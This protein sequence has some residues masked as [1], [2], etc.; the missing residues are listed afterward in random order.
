MTNRYL[1]LKN[2]LYSFCGINRLIHSDKKKGIGMITGFIFIMTVF[3]LYE[4]MFYLSLAESEMAEC[5]PSL[6]VLISSLISLFLT[7]LKSQ[8]AFVGMKDY[9]MTMSLPVKEIDIIIS[10]FIF[11]YII[12]SAI[13]LAVG[14]PADVVYAVSSSA[15]TSSWIIFGI[16]LLFIPVIPMTVSLIAGI[17]I[18][19][20]SLRSKHRNAVSIILSF[21]AVI[22]IVLFSFRTQN[23]GL[24]RM[25]D[26][27]QNISAAAENLYLPAEML[28][29]AVSESSWLLLLLFSVFSVMPALIFIFILAKYYKRINTASLSHSL[30]YNM[31]Q[32]VIR[33]SVPFTALYRKELKMFFS[34]T[35]Y[36][37]NSSVGMV[38]MAVTSIFIIFIPIG[39]LGSLHQMIRQTVPLIGAVFV[40]ISSTTSSSLSLEGDK[41]WIMCSLPVASSEIVKSKIALNLTIIVPLL[42]ISSAAAG[43]GLKLDLFKIITTIAVAASY[44]LYIS[45]L[46]IYINVKF[47]KYDWKSEY[48]AVKGSVSVLLTA[49]IGIASSLI[50]LMMC[51]SFSRYSSMLMYCSS[52][53]VITAAGILYR[54]ISSVRLYAM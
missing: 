37:L 40:S 39:S 16:A 48:Y 24:D 51:I 22:I 30:N 45:V 6:V 43:I 13:S 1:L 25:I 54:K 38:L 9:D 23:I 52:A 18:K 28:A 20:L 32:K 44:G 15:N 34:C 10:R 2:H 31:K 4:T 33:P 21:A 17:V 8:G 47:P 12:N 29:K 41:R 53:A 27:G 26:L 35:V 7:F 3:I 50:P 46:G 42:I 14:L 19:A 49:I 36:A 5:L 11:I